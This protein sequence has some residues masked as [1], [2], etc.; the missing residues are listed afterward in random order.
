MAALRDELHRRI[1]RELPN[2]RLNGHP[3][4]RLPNTLN[5]SLPGARATE[6]LAAA[7]EV[8]A[9]AGSACASESPEPSHVLR[10]MG[11]DEEDA[12]ASVRLSLGRFTTR[13][14]VE[15]A[16]DTLV[17]AVRSRAAAV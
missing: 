9:S 3:D 16:A 5:L 7:P 4:E 17:R 11:V 15:R 13:E 12:L 8:A 14:E 10:A 6:L 2:A 1:L